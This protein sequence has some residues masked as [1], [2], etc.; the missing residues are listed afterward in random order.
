MTSGRFA[1]LAAVATVVV[2]GSLL[3]LAPAA[4]DSNATVDCGDACAPVEGTY[5]LAFQDDAGLPAE[6]VNLN[7]Q[8]LAD[9]EPLAIQRTDGGILTGSLKGVA[10]TGQVYA[11]GFLTL[12]GTPPPSSDGGVSTFFSLT[13]T[14]TGSPEDGGGGS[15]SGNFTG[16][17]SRI[18]GTS[19]LRCNV[20]RPFTATRQ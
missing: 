20:T 14:I 11:S 10:L 8:A 1:P 9:G 4:C 16:N 17:Y 15:L 13:A 7:V 19:A 12:T 3:L 5:P 18:Q 6:C 2:S